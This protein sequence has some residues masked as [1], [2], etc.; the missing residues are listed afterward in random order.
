M[1]FHDVGVV[2]VVVSVLLVYDDDD[3]DIVDGV[4]VLDDAYFAIV[5]VRGTGCMYWCGGNGVVDI[6]GVGGVFGV[7]YGD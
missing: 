3:G 5:G 2:V 1:N 6:R 7:E 4:V